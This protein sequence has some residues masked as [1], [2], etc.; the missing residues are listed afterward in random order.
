MLRIHKSSNGRVLFTLSGRINKEHITELE[1]VIRSETNDRPI[2]LDLK[3]VTLVDRD[4]IAFL[5]G[6]EA[7]NIALVNCPPYIRE[8][9]TQGRR[10]A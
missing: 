6:C 7:D 1:S 5:E 3:N 8:W 2:A 4:V 9:I 10:M